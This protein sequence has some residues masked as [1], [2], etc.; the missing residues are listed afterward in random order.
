NATWGE[1]T[2]DAAWLVSNRYKEQAETAAKARSQM[3]EPTHFDMKD[4]M[5]KGF[6]KIA[7]GDFSDAA[8]VFSSI[9]DKQQEAEEKH[10]EAVQVMQNMDS[11]YYQTASTQPMF[12]KPPEPGDS[13]SAGTS[14]ASYIPGSDGSGGVTSPGRP[15]GGVTGGSGPVS[16]GAGTS[17]GSTLSGAP[18]TT[19]RSYSGTGPMP[20]TSPTENTGTTSTPSYGG[21]S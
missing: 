5:T 18:G 7:Q 16:A 11:G 12:A 19:G 21:S 15:G 2:R 1:D 13:S 17:G 10:A 8:D 6:T 9:P 20:S 3:P 14:T 4:E